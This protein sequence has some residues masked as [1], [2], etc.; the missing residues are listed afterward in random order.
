MREGKSLSTDRSLHSTA[1]PE[2][3][4]LFAGY[5]HFRERAAS[6]RRRLTGF[7]RHGVLP[8][9]CLGSDREGHISPFD[10][11][12][13]PSF[14]D[15]PQDIPRGC[16]VFSHT[17]ACN[18]HVEPPLCLQPASHLDIIQ[19]HLAR[20]VACLARGPIVRNFDGVGG[21]CATDQEERSKEPDT[22]SSYVRH[23][24]IRGNSSLCAALRN[25]RA[26][27]VSPFRQRVV[28]NI[29][30]GFCFGSPRRFRPCNA[31]EGACRPCGDLSAPRNANQELAVACRLGR[32]LLPKIRSHLRVCELGAHDCAPK[33][34]GRDGRQQTTVGGRPDSASA[35]NSQCWSPSTLG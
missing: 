5:A 32:R 14:L 26:T 15:E 7:A 12:C 8:P 34:L 3:R 1:A 18:L 33:A 10:P 11:H 20:L 2:G 30:F 27:P 22:S 13:L 9:Q 19:A 35:V 29:P 16:A 6:D 24:G 28:F 25:Q 23:H 31:S 17:R 4:Q 21:P